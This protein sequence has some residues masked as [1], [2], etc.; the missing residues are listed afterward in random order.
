MLY[1]DGMIHNYS[2]MFGM[3]R[4]VVRALQQSRVDVLA[5]QNLLKCCA[6]LM[7][8]DVS[9]VVIKQPAFLLFEYRKC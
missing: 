7:Q 3:C 5:Q 6:A 2:I 1:G 4:H 8:V 9:V